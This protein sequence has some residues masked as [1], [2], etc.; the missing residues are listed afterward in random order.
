MGTWSFPAGKGLLLAVVVAVVAAAV[1]VLSEAGILVLILSEA[2][3]NRL[4][5]VGTCCSLRLLSMSGCWG[6]EVGDG[7][8]AAKSNKKYQL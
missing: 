4:I 8:S 5:L 1:L 7:W 3:E 6:W 2:I